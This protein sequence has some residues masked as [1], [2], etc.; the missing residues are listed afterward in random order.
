MRYIKDGKDYAKRIVRMYTGTP[1]SDFWYENALMEHID[2][3]ER[4]GII[5]SN[6]N[7]FGKGYINQ[8]VKMEILP[9]WRKIK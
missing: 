4:N 9:S 6:C 2:R 8:L 3:M 7:K 5:K 1:M